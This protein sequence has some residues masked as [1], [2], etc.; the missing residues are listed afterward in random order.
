M[1]D[2]RVSAGEP[3]PLEPWER[4]LSEPVR[5]RPVIVGFELLVGMTDTVTDLARWGARRP[6]LIADGRGTG[7]IPDPDAADVLLVEEQ[8][9][10]SLTEQV[11]ARMRPDERLTPDV[12]EAVERYDPAGDAVWWVSP[13]AL[14][15][16]M[17]GR[18]VNGG[19]PRSQAML[20][21]KLLVDG[22]LDAVGAP[23]PPSRTARTAYDVLMQ[24]TREVTSETGVEQVVWAGDNRGGTNGG[25][26]FIRWIRS[27]ELAQEAAAFFAERCD[28]VRVS[29]FLDGVPCSVHGIVLP[30]GIVVLRPVELV[31]LRD[32]DRG[33]FVYGGMG[34]SWSPRP[35][36]AAEMRD[37][38]ARVGRHLQLEHGYRGGFGIDGVLTSEGFRVTEL[39]AR[40]SGGLARLE[41][42]A[43]AAQLGLVHVNAVLGR[44][45]GRPATDIEQHAMA[46]LAENPFVDTFGLSTRGVVD[47]HAE[48]L[49][50]A[51]DGC[52]EVAD[53]EETMIGTVVGGPSA[54]GSFFRFLS[55]DGI[56]LEGERAAPLSVLLHDFVNRTWDAGIPTGLIAP[57]LRP[58][59]AGHEHG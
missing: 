35:D 51:G 52:L 50:Q 7:A 16:P 13:V 45:V 37:L 54:L 46:L 36:D 38:A 33:V 29:A 41:R 43:P 20:E 15:E 17:L 31:A 39:N 27:L 14:N 9:A 59:D 57:D 44:D 47:D 19:R 25:G 58:R 34:T 10:G 3:E 6:L 23:R 53:S 11:R 40:F 2:V 5:G 4:H 49:V 42:A 28:Q 21:D 26:D 32:P 22:L 24:A 18:A 12:V 1:S 30:D 8:R 48:I 56:V 55:L